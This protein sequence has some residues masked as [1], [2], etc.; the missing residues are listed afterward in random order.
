MRRKRE[1]EEKEIDCVHVFTYLFLTGIS[2]AENLRKEGFEGRIVLIGQEPHLPYDRTK[3]SKT[4]SLAVDKMHFRAP[5]FFA[6]A[7]IET[8]LGVE[9][10]EIDAAQKTVS[11]SDGA[12]VKYDRLFVATGA[13]PRLLNCPGSNLPGI[14]CL[15][16]PEEAAKILSLATKETRLVIVG[17]SFIGMETAAV[18]FDK[19]ASVDVIGMEKTPFERVLGAE[20]GAALQRFHEEKGKIRFHLTRVVSEFQ[21]ENGKLT[22]VLLDNGTLLPASLVVM[23]AGVVPATSFFKAGVQKERDN[24][25]VVDE[26]LRAAD[27]LFCGGDIARYPFHRTANSLVR[28]EHI[29]MAMYHGKIAA[30]NMLDRNVKV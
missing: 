24:S 12:V 9:A 3:L 27:G 20:V 18:L 17:S 21:G 19:V 23:G 10:R 16:V 4:M 14:H 25:I 26:Y 30:L 8:I 13:T 5:A 22:G 2:C 6:E 15:R 29:G 28:I 1:N 11:L 7:N